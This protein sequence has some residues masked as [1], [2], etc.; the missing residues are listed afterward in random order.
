[1]S[2]FKKLVIVV[3][4]LVV[5][6]VI[7][8]FVFVKFNRSEE[9]WSVVYLTSGEIYIGKLSYPIYF[10]RDLELADAY[11]FRFSKTSAAAEQAPQTNIQLNPVKDA[12][13]APQN[14]YVNRE[15]VV[16]YGPLAETSTAAEAIK[17][18]GK[19]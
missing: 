14:F 19:W 7:I 9:K 12:L 3:C 1:M 13:W 17:E 4:V 2:K 15:Q 10:S 16:F 5:L 8:I 11:I 18:S 6:V